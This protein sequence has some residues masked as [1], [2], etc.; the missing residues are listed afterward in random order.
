MHEANRPFL[1]ADGDTDFLVHAIMHMQ[2]NNFNVTFTTSG[3]WR[4]PFSNSTNPSWW[5][6][7]LSS[8]RLAARGA[9]SPRFSPAA[10][11]GSA[12]KHR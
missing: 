6:H 9:V 3:I 4:K 5:P 10:S 12:M 1:P 7:C 11:G 8:L 2:G